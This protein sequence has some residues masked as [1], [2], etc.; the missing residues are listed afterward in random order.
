M[1]K[2][3]LFAV[4]ALVAL[5]ASAKI[6]APK[7]S[8]TKFAGKAN[9]TA[10]DRMFAD[11][12][13]GLKKA[14][15]KDGELPTII[16]EQ[17]EGELVQYNRKEGLEWY[18]SGGVNIYLQSGLVNVVYS[19]DDNTVWI[20][21]PVCAYA[22]DA[23]I[24]GEVVNGGK[25]LQF[26]VGQYLT[27]NEDYGYGVQ[28]YYMTPN[29]DTENISM[30]YELATIDETYDFI[31]YTVDGNYLVLDNVAAFNTSMAAYND[32]TLPL[33]GNV[34]GCAW[35]DDQ[36]FAPYCEWGTTMEMFSLDDVPVELPEGAVTEE[37]NL[38][39][40]VSGSDLSQKINVA[41]VDNDIYV[42]DFT[43][44][45]P[46][47]WIKGTIDG[48][49]VKFP[50]QYL[51]LY[52]DTYLMYLVGATYDSEAGF[53][54]TE[55]SGFEFSYDADTR[56]L[57]QQTPYI[58]VTSSKTE[59]GYYA[60]AY[61]LII[62]NEAPATPSDPTIVAFSE[63]QN[64]AEEG[65]EDNYYGFVIANIPTTDTEGNDMLLPK[66]SYRIY[67]D[68]EGDTAVVAFGTNEIT[69]LPSQGGYNIQ[70][71]TDTGIA[72]I[73]YDEATADFN[74][75]GVQAVYTGGLEEH[76]S[77][78][79]WHFIKEYAPAG[80]PGDI[81]G[82]GQID[83][84]DVSALLEMVLSGGLTEEQKTIADLTGDGEVDGADVS[85]LLEIV[86]NGE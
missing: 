18:Y 36:S 54:L 71:L 59:T 10:T 46:E 28:V 42:Q 3:T 15:L 22:N 44:Y 66:L 78:I 25:T 53:E 82:D 56:T 63:Y 51:G 19:E 70:V 29:Q 72:T 6:E 81:N 55:D 68:I 1:K 57:I 79:V 86:L 5:A 8:F 31:T 24:V 2:I 60:Y 7:A 17:P 64:H 85:A 37:F 26:P 65:E 75:I 80:I 30:V 45:F 23:W 67:R 77:N 38:A 9:I 32:F 20:Q 14:S 48:D 47:G 13:K 49:V 43:G 40:G 52:Y 76:K 84:A 83:G 34:L 33:Q 16:T 4:A 62:S 73:L 11:H 39:G 69:D 74:S 21:N 61:D 50:A 35:S 41:F 58:L 12:A 27:Y